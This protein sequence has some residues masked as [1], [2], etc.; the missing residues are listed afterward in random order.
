MASTTGLRDT[1]HQTIYINNI[2]EK[3][4]KQELTTNLYLLLSQFGHIL[5]VNS[6]TSF[7]CRGQAWVVFD[8]TDAATR[9]VRAMSGFNFFGK[10]LRCSFAESKSDTI[11]K[12]EGTY[13][14]RPKRVD[15]KTKN[16]EVKRETRKR[17]DSP[18]QD[19]KSTK[20]V[21]ESKSA[22]E[23]MQEDTNPP[24]KILFVEN[25]PGATTATLLEMLFQ[26]SEGFVEARLIPGKSGIAFVEFG[27]AFQ[28]EQ[29]KDTLQGFKIS[30]NNQMRISYAK[31]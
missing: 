5:E 7:R 27:D 6:G 11:S 13:K 9:A 18:T 23:P 24:N 22:P 1:P 31:Q 25:L 29:A 21:A 26:Q 17:P 19:S 8:K 2:N 20:R 3:L 16:T 12:I 28:A 30:G 4:K 10:P 15:G 14:P